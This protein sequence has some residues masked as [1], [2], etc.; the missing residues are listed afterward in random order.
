MDMHK[1]YSVQVTQFITTEEFV[2][3]THLNATQHHY[4]VSE[5][6]YT[7]ECNATPCDPM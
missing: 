2:S 1:Q 3:F 5:D 6:T 4:K 7:L